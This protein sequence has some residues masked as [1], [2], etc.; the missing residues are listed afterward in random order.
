LLHTLLISGLS[1]AVHG[2]GF[3]RN[4][5]RRFMKMKEKL[6]QQMSVHA[7]CKDNQILAE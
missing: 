3:D 2:L 7:V 4:L 5:R 6:L 1:P